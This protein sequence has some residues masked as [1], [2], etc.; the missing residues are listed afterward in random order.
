M[1]LGYRI[2]RCIY[3]FTHSYV[4]GYITML[5]IMN[6]FLVCAALLFGSLSSM[7]THEQVIE[8]DVSGLTCSFCVYG[9]QSNLDKHT[10][11]EKAEISLKQSKARIHLTPGATVT[12]EELKEII[13]DAGFA[14]GESQ[15]YGRAEHPCETVA[16]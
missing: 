14:S 3:C 7:A 6:K 16:C 1:Y 4:A 12:V 5:N 9:L 2:Y 8:I 10:E 11:V 13:K 15:H